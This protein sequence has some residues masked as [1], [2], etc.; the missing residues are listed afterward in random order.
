MKNMINVLGKLLLLLSV[1]VVGNT[2][3]SAQDYYD[4]SYSGK[5]VSLGITLAPNVSWLRYGDQE[6][7]EKKAQI[8][9]AYGLLSDFSLSENY[10][11]STGFLINTLK[12]SSDFN[13]AS[14]TTYQLQ[15]VEI[16]F[17]LKL[18]DRKSVV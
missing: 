2:K 15:Y 1:I 3:V 8:G 9:Y 11:F 5:K 16:P 7:I 17:G 14:T 13:A 12:A 10:Y 4:S 6:N 18:Q